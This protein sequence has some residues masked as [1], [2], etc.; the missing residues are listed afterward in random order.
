MKTEKYAEHKNTLKVMKIILFNLKFDR[1]IVL[2]QI[3]LNKSEQSLE[4]NLMPEEQYS[5]NLRRVNT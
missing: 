2:S 3:V 1:N 4:Y 5:P